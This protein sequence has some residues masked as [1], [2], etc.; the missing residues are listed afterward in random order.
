MK[1]KPPFVKKLGEFPHVS[2]GLFAKDAPQKNNPCQ[3][4]DW[5]QT[6]S[7]WFHAFDRREWVHLLAL[8]RASFLKK[9]VKRVFA[10]KIILTSSAAK[11]RTPDRSCTCVQRAEWLFMRA[12]VNCFRSVH[13]N[14]LLNALRKTVVFRSLGSFDRTFQWLELGHS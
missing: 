2:M 8:D 10:L 3:W 1:E 6:C 12:H 14:N 13:V 5:K 7:C 4:L 9:I 11:K